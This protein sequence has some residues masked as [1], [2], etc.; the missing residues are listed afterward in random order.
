MAG[1]FQYTTIEELFHE[2]LPPI[3]IP[4]QL[5]AELERKVLLEVKKLKQ[6]ATEANMPGGS[7]LAQSSYLHGGDNHGTRQVF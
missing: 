1:K 2:G 6:Q 7:L 3:Q 4:P 5:S